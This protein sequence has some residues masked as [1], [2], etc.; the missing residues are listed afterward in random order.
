MDNVNKT[1]YIPLYGK[2]FVSAKGI[3]LKDKKAEEIWEKEGFALKGKSKSKWLAYYMSMRARVFDEWVKNAVEE[4]EDCIVLHIGCGMDSRVERIG[5]QT[6]W[7][8]IDFPQVIEARKKYYQPSESY[9]MLGADIRHGEWLSELPKAKNAVFV[10]E[11]VSMYLTSEE[12]QA[13]LKNLAER[14]DNVRLMVDCY[15]PLAAKLSKHRNPINDVGVTNV[16]GVDEPNTLAQDTGFSLVQ[17]WELTPV[18]MINE[19]K[20]M[21]KFIFQKLYAGSLSKK[22]YKLYEYKKTRL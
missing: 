5:V 8:D 12:R 16:Y 22:L 4:S 7:V 13:L 9:R 17:E 11:G 15:T 2:A 14:F 1:L 10:M 18:Y 3:V 19:L 20:G 21:E 6:P